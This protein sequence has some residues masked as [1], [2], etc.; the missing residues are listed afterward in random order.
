[1]IALKISL[2]VNQATELKAKVKIESS[3]LENTLPFE[4]LV[5]ET[6]P[7]TTENSDIQLRISN[8]NM[9]TIENAATHASSNAGCY[10][11][12]WWQRLFRPLFPPKD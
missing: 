2:S 10:K 8:I 12:P 6:L 5:I 9:A 11:K 3:S 7:S 4:N 1:M